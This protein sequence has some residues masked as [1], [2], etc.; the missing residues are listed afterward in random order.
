MTNSALDIFQVIRNSEIDVYKNNIGNYD[1]NIK[2]EFGQSLLHEAIAYK[3]HEIAIDLLKRSINVNIQDGK[4]QTVLHFI[5]F[6]PDITI[7]EIIV[8]SGG[9]L[10]LIDSYGNTPLWYAVFNAKGM[11]EIVKLFMKYRANPISKNRAGRSVVDF[12]NQIKD[13]TLLD[14]LL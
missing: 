1:I 11:Y 5:S 7:A 4:G 3:Q 6:H 2:N 14:L 13:E 9:N 10:E 12:A 8:E